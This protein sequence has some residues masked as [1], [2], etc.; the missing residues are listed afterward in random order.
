MIALLKKRK[1][2]VFFISLIQ[3]FSCNSSF[4]V[5]EQKLL[6]H[7]KDKYN[8]AFKVLNVEYII[9]NDA[10]RIRVT[11]VD[12]PNMEV[13]VDYRQNFPYSDNYLVCKFN[14]EATAYLKKEIK[15]LNLSFPFS[16]VAGASTASDNLNLRQLPNWE[17][18]FFSNTKNNGFTCR[19]NFFSEPND[20]ALSAL[21]KLDKKF[22]KNEVRKSFFFCEFY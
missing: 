12:N 22:R 15:S 4:F 21:L 11:P 20:E 9:G 6:N 19:I 2:I 18:I 16:C 10:Y 7:L 14:Q 3:L 17:T 8:V 5:D 1:C 13:T